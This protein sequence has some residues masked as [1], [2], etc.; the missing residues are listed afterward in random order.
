MIRWLLS[1]ADIPDDFTEDVQAELSRVDK[2]DGMILE[3]AQL[4]AAFVK[5]LNDGSQYRSRS[6][7]TV[8]DA[9]DVYIETKIAI[10][11]NHLSDRIEE[12]TGVRP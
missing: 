4:I 9:L 6:I 8:I 12:K 3:T 5:M 2:G 11:L 7:T 1:M 10:A